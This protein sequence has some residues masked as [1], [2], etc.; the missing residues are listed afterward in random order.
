LLKSEVHSDAEPGEAVAGTI[1]DAHGDTLRVQTG[2]GVLR[3]LVLQREGRR[4]LTAREFLAGR[5]ISPGA[6]FVPS[7]T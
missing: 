6:R 2:D 3:V 1:I 5:R 4:P 7:G